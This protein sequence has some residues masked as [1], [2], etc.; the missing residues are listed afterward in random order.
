M[1]QISAYKRFI[2]LAK[3]F[4]L[5]LVSTFIIYK[6]FFAYKVN[7]L[8]QTFDMSKDVA[9][10]GYVVLTFF[11]LFINY[12]LEAFKWKNLISRF[13][14]MLF[15]TAVKAVLSGTA[16]NIITPNQMGDFAGRVIHLETMNKWRGSLV[17]AIGHFAQVIVTLFFGLCSFAYFGKA[18]FNYI[19]LLPLGFLLVFAIL[20]IYL[21]MFWFYQKIKHLP[22]IYKI[23]KYVDVFAYFESKQL[24]QILAISFVRYLVYLSQYFLLLQFFKV[25]IDF[26]PAFACIIGTFCVQSVVPSFLLLEIGLRGASALAFFSLLSTNHEGILLSAYSLWIVNILVPAIFGMYFIYKV[27]S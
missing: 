19:Y 16:F 6:L 14:P 20:I 26:V 21:R 8:F 7:T 24:L 25:D 12:G 27:R 23:E 3:I 1:F 15:S 13:E 2:K 5:L 9:S 4:F 10:W 22:F 17:T 18:Y 11:L